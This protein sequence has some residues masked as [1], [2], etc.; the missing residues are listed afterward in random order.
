MGG[1][2]RTERDSIYVRFCN[3]EISEELDI[4]FLQCE[5]HT[6]WAFCSKQRIPQKKP[7]L[8]SLLGSAFLTAL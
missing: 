7:G 5:V 4:G 3:S 1:Q 8:P 6:V 2:E